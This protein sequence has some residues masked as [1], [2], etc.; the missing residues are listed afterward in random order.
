M[1]ADRKEGSKH[2][3]LASKVLT[4][5]RTSSGLLR[6]LSSKKPAAAMYGGKRMK[7]FKIGGNEKCG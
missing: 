4:A 2:S 1:A 5:L 6:Y 7:K 3:S